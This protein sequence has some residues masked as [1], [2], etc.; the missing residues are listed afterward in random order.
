MS[1]RAASLAVLER[2]VAAVAPFFAGDAATQARTYAPGKWTVRQ[3]LLHLADSQTAMLDRLF[4]LAG[5]DAPILMNFD[6]N[7]W[8]ERLAYDRRDLA[9]AGGL[10]RAGAA[11][12]ADLCRTLPPTADARQGMH[13]L[14]GL[15]SFAQQL[16]YC[17]EHSAH[18]LEQIAAAAAGRSWPP[19]R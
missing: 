6:E 13:S 14:G 11:T 7:R 10:Y 9:V 19:A 17:A 5:E 8:A 1:D 18:H 4:R 2:A 3:L 12:I 16:A 15:R